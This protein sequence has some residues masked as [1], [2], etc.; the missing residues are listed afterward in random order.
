[1]AKKFVERAKLLG[2]KVKGNPKL[3]WVGATLDPSSFCRSEFEESAHAHVEKCSSCNLEYATNL[4]SS[5]CPN[6]GGESANDMDPDAVPEDAIE[7]F[8]DDSQLAAI[9]CP[10]CG[11]HNVVTEHTAALLNGK[12]RCTACATPVDYEVARTDHVFDADNEGDTNNISSDERPDILKQGGKTK[13]M[14]APGNRLSGGTPQGQEKPVDSDVGDMLTNEIFN[15]DAND[16]VGDYAAVKL[17]DVV[18]ADKEVAFLAEPT[19]LFLMVG[20]VVVAS[21]DKEKSGDAKPLFNKPK[22]M[23]VLS[24]LVKEGGVERVLAAY[25]WDMTYI[26]FPFKQ[27]VAEH[28]SQETASVRQSFEEQAKVYAED[29]EQ[30]MSLASAGMIRNFFRGMTN[31]IREALVQELSTAGLHNPENLVDRV[32]ASYGDQYNKTLVEKAKELRSKPVDVRNGLAEALSDIDPKAQV[33]QAA[34]VEV[35]NF[36]MRLENAAYAAPKTTEQ[37]R[38]KSGG[39]IIK[40]IQAETGLNGSIFSRN[41]LGG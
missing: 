26:D 41:R 16:D 2:D 31:P 40:A 13:Q 30:C 38:S 22:F 36:G 3:V 27:T 1:M 7:Q 32:F 24:S 28:V 21:L 33:A 12:I 25:D 39:S 34:P 11:V 20:D 6:C 8:P 23:T 17:L 35:A 14:I 29:M 18:P 9:A 37:P 10:K 5:Y 4:P 19:K 15:G